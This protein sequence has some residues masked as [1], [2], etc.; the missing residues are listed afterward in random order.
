MSVVQFTPW[1]LRSTV[2]HGLGRG[3][4]QLGFPTANL[5]LN[6]A[7]VEKLS[8]FKETVLYG[9]GCVEADSQDSYSTFSG[10]YPI[11]MSVGT[12]P[13][14]QNQH[15]SV[16]PHFIH[17]FSE[18]FYGQVVRILVLGVIRNSVAFTTIDKLIETIR[19]D[20]KKAEEML[21]ESIALTAKASD[22]LNPAIPLVK[23][24]VPFFRFAD[25]NE[26]GIT[27]RE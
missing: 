12:N 2:I 13:H 5:E 3:G 14:F 4:S 10:P 6:E 27:L 7:V 20:V 18:D 9:W 8:L 16:E 26:N 15:I 1:V 23:G 11:A 22:F 17:K 24:E 25:F 21:N 19:N